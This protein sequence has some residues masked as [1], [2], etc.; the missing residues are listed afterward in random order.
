MPIP[1]WRLVVG[2]LHTR[3]AVTYL[4]KRKMLLLVDCLE[5]N[6]IWGPVG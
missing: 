5:R 4:A 1:S 2:K 3:R 6:I